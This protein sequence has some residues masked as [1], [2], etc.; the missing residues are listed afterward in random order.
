[1]SSFWAGYHG[2]ALVLE[3]KDMKCFLQNCV[4]T[5]PDVENIDDLMDYF[6][7]NLPVFSWKSC[8][9][10]DIV[11]IDSDMCEGMKLFPYLGGQNTAGISKRIDFPDRDLIVVYAEHQLDSYEALCERPY[12]GYEDL[13]QRYVDL[14]Q[15]YLPSNFEWDRYIGSFSYAVYA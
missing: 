2:T 4:D 13:K 15:D 9:P 5:F 12:N 3:G 10:V 1:M 11:K 8:E 7:D 14:L 6:N